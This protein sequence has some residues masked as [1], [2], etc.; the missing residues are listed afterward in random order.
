MNNICFDCSVYNIHCSVEPYLLCLYI[1][2]LYIKPR[3]KR[4]IKTDRNTSSLRYNRIIFGAKILN[5]NLPEFDNEVRQWS[6]FLWKLK[7]IAAKPGINLTLNLPHLLRLTFQL[8]QGVSDRSYLYQVKHQ[9]NQV[10]ILHLKY[11]K[12]YFNLRQSTW[13]W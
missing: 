13:G 4:K 9:W 6:L 11:I 7:I 5:K 3:Q 10:R 8:L 2:F 12:I 1:H